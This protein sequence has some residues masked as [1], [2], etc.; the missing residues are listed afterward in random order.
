MTILLHID[1]IRKYSYFYFFCFIVFE[2]LKF[3]VLAVSDILNLHKA[4]FG[5]ILYKSTTASSGFNTAYLTQCRISKYTRLKSLSWF[6]KC[7]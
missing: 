5:K 6:I 1:T 2:S 4:T 7:D 3:K